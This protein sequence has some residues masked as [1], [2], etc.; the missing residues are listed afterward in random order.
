MRDVIWS[1]LLSVGMLGMMPHSAAEDIT[2]IYRKVDQTVLAISHPPNNPQNELQSLLATQ[3]GSALDYGFTTMPR[4]TYA[5]RRGQ[6]VKITP[7]G[8]VVLIPDPAVQVREV[9]KTATRAKLL[10]LGFTQ[11]EVDLV[12]P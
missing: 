2:I 10:A 5:N 8:K 11:E 12:V 9:T 4:A 3:G 7:T 6:W 1:V